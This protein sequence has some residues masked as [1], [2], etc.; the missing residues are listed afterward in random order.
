MAA[1]ALPASL[2]AGDVAPISFERQIKPVI[3][4]VCVKCH[5]ADTAKGNLDLSARPTEDHFTRDPR[6]LEKILRLV[7]DREMPP[8]GKRPQP[9]EQDRQLLIDWGDYALAH[10]DYERFP[11]N[12]GRVVIHRLSHSEYNNT[13]RDLLGVTNNPAEQFPADGGGG[14]GFDNNADTLFV[15]PLLMEKYLEVTAQMLAATKPE[16]LAPHRPGLFVTKSSAARRNIE[17]FASRA[18]RRP[19]EAAEMNSL[20]AV[21]SSALRRETFDDAVRSAFTAVL[22]SPNFLFRVERDQPSD[23]PYRI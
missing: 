15:P 6:E 13:V 4:A 14:G 23:A 8:P 17:Q 22:V 2:L 11:K 19:I 12:P 9:K 18:F 7:R 20:M 10:I 16:R 5:D 21:F 1:I 3:E